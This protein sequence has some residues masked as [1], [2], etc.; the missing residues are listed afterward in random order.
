[1][2]DLEVIIQKKVL[3]SNYI[4]FLVKNILV[5]TVFI[6]FTK[7]QKIVMDIIYVSTKNKRHKF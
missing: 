7:I 4:K 5:T 6:F 3:D 1:M 2:E